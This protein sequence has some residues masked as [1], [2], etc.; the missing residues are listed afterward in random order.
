MCLN[1]QYSLFM[2]MTY[3]FYHIICNDKYVNFLGVFIM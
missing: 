3:F 1:A 2:Y